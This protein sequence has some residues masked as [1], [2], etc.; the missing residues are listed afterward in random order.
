M[1]RRTRRSA[2]LA[3]LSVFTLVAV[4]CG[5]DDDDDDTAGTEAVSGTEAASETRHRRDRGQARRHR[6]GDGRAPTR[7]RDRRRWGV[8]GA[9]DVGGQRRAGAGWHARLRLEADTA[10]PWAPYRASSATSCRAIL[11]AI[12]DP[13]F[14]EDPDGKPVRVPRRVGRAQRR[15]HR[16][17]ADD[18]RRH[19]VPRRH[20]ARRRRRRVQHRVVPV[21]PADRVRVRHD[22]RRSRRR[23]RTYVITTKGPW[24]ALPTAFL[25]Y[26]PCSFMFSPEWL[27]SL[28]DVP[29]RTEGTPVYDAAL[30]ATPADGDPAAAGRARRVQVRVVRP[31]QRQH[32]LV[33]PQRGLLARAERHHRRGPAVP[34]RDRLRRRRRRGDPVELDA[35]GRVRSHDDGERR[36]DQPVHRRRRLQGRRLDEVR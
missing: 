20:A 13:L 24:V 4:A 10:N 30:A 34:R 31:G 5:G 14:S 26:D 23:A 25:D 28:A 6:A 17:D 7:R 29:Q 2:V 22:R 19:Q 8:G 21:Q 3:T 36:H 35:V 27:A 32:V 12:S 18:P 33:G 11:K 16:V 9:T 1:H 15:L